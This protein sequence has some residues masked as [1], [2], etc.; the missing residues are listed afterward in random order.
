MHRPRMN[1][2]MQV[3]LCEELDA[4]F[5]KTV[6]LGPPVVH[7]CPQ[8]VSEEKALQNC[9]RHSTNKKYTDTCLC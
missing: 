3:Q 2:M 4:L 8:A 9:I 1:V 7:G 6:V 5:L